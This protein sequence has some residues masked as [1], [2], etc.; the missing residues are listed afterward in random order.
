MRERL[1][2]RVDHAPVPIFP[3]ALLRWTDFRC[4]YCHIVFRRDYW[5]DNV[6]LGNGE[7]TCKGCAK[8]FDDGTR[9]WPELKFGRRLRYLLPPGIII[10]TAFFL[11]FSV[12]TLCVA[13]S[14][15]V[16]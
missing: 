5:P 15:V 4:P 1:A 3:L 8:V 6:R 10:M 2:I 14:D 7:R 12:G 13:P 9:E 11:I 16:N